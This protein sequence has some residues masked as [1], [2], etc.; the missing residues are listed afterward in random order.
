MTQ[1]ERW[2]ELDRTEALIVELTGQ[3]TRPFFRS[4]YGDGADDPTVQ[5]D[6]AAR[7]YAY[8]IFWT[9]DSGG[10]RG[11]P[12]RTIIDICLRGTRPGAIYVMH[13]GAASQD[14]LALSAVIEGLANAGYDFETI[15]EIVQP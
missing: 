15:E 14:G 8:N 11:Y 13:V 5:R 7:G 10:W 9:V 3:S 6:I 4:P 1:A 2:S 12:A